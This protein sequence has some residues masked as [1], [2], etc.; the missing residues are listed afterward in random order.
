MCAC[1]FVSSAV[2]LSAC[3]HVYPFV[4]VCTCI[5]ACGLSAYVSVGTP[6]DHAMYNT[7]S[8]HVKATGL[9]RLHDL[10]CSSVPNQEGNSTWHKLC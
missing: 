10:S 1:L 9:V 5:F 6:R 2:C 3:L 7:R 4:S 8:C